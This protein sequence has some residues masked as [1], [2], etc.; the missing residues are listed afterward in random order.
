MTP[1][2]CTL[3]QLCCTLF[4]KNPIFFLNLFFFFRFIEWGECCCSGGRRDVG[5]GIKIKGEDLVE[6]K[7]TLV[8]HPVRSD[9]C[10]KLAELPS[11]IPLYSG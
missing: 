7:D 2:G 10:K 4:F 3:L 11:T 1:Q 5:V 8:K 6:C 9:A